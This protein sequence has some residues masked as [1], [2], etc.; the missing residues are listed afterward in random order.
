M[1]QADVRPAGLDVLARTGSP[2]AIQLNFP[3]DFLDGRT[4]SASVGGT[5]I[6]PSI[7][8]DE[9]TLALSG[10]QTTALGNGRHSILL[11]DTTG[12]DVVRISGRLLL[13][14]TSTDSPDTTV[15]ILTADAVEVDV[16]VVSADVA[17]AGATNL[18]Y[19]ASPTNGVVTSDSGT[20]ATVPLS[21]GTNAGLLSPAQHSKLAGI[22]AGAQVN[23]VTQAELDDA[24]A[25]LSGTY[26]PQDLSTLTSSASPDTD[27]VIPVHV[28]G[29]LRKVTIADILA[30]ATGGGFTQEQIEDFVG[31]M[32]TDNSVIDF[33]Y[34]DATGTIVATIKAASVTAAM[35]SDAELAALGGLTSAAD[36]LPY[37]TGSGTASLADLT[38]AGRA[39]LDDADAAAQLTTLGISA[40]VQTLLD[41]ANAAT[42]RTTLGL[43]NVDN[44]SDANKPV[45]TA[46]QTALDAKAGTGLSFVTVSSEATL[47]GETTFQ[48]A[49]A[50][51]RQSV[52][53]TADETINNSA[54]LQNDDHLAF[55]IGASEVW[56]A[57]YA[58]FAVAGSQTADL[59]VA[60]TV[61]ASATLLWN[62]FGIRGTD[63]LLTNHGAITAG[64][65]ALTI[66]NGA[67]G[68]PIYLITIDLY[69]AGGGT[70]G[71]VQMQWAQGVATA[72]D[73]TIKAG[74]H[75]VAQRIA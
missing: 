18:G 50:A 53:K 51:W 63:A 74:S 15:T 75:L 8:G 28:D 16:T 45:S 59:Q 26:V 9:M 5:A 11:V 40:F 73:S 19:T 31:A 21:D 3:A 7:A 41:D 27:D 22:E 61:P 17:A 36:K 54:A 70:G 65:T 10:A 29:A 56:T 52:R 66:Q 35:M 13:G 32:A 72:S 71:T 46:T 69:V 64:G 33:T 25:A 34:D 23:E 12:D 37:F 2:V 49:L 42:A 62:A 48:S 6:T 4:W 60:F 1:P 47:S 55:T 39:L 57:R 58:L 67:V 43:G 14:T 20:D 38:A 24:I 68:S 44:T 30:L